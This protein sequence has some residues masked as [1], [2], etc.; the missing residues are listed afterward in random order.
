MTQIKVKKLYKFKTS[1]DGMKNF[2]NY[3]VLAT[4]GI[5]AAAKLNV[6]L[7]K[8]RNKKQETAEEVKII[9]IIDLE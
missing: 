2:N 6:L 1:Y 8:K 5:T 3:N 4:N 9:G 7:F